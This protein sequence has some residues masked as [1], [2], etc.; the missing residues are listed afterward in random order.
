MP[1][2]YGVFEDHAVVT[3]YVSEDGVDIVYIPNEVNGVPVTEIGPGTF[4]KTANLKTVII[5]M[6][7][8][9][10]GEE[11]FAYCEQLTCVGVAESEQHSVFPPSL[12]YIGESAFMRTGL[13]E[14]SFASERIELDRFC[15]Q[16]AKINAAY[17]IGTDITLRDGVFSKSDI[18]VMAMKNAEVNYIGAE[19]FS[20]C[21]NLQIIKAKRI[22][23][24]GEDCFR[25]CV[26]LGE[27]PAKMPL[28]RVGEGAFFNCYSLK[29]AGFFRTMRDM[30]YAWGVAYALE[31]TIKHKC[32]SSSWTPERYGSANF[33]I[34]NAANML[35]KKI[36]NTTYHATTDFILLRVIGSEYH[37][38]DDWDSVDRFFLYAK[39][40]IQERFR[41]V[42]EWNVIE[43]Q[44]GYCIPPYRYIGDLSAEEVYRTLQYENTPKPHAIDWDNLSMLLNAEL[45]GDRAKDNS[46]TVMSFLSCLI[47]HE[48]GKTPKS[49]Y[50]IP[51]VK[52]A[53]DCFNDDSTFLTD[54]ERLHYLT[55]GVLYNRIVLY[56]ELKHA[57]SQLMCDEEIEDSD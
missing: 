9:S 6:T 39:K 42:W 12:R 57:R 20:F 51:T 18:Q 10:I 5:P 40:D 48:I 47:D 33:K 41:D 8:E 49:Y 54:E 43:E 14:L 7:L 2:L 17:F 53:E 4:R 19:C 16:E 11:A 38:P 52:I 56:R 21:K 1:L 28:D 25:E 15:F 26:S 55:W 44:C 31:E 34:A 30:I 36:K 32:P 24:V 27:F 37:G 22:N 35:V 23:G 45:G 46:A 50:E 3:H 29:T 13:R